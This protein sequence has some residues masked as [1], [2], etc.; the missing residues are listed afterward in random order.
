MIADT[1]AAQEFKLSK[2]GA[3]INSSCN[4]AN[5]GFSSQYTVNSLNEIETY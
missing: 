2:R 1:N 3:E 5:C 4:P